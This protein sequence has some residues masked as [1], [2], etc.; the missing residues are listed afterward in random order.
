MREL[1]GDTN[2]NR[3]TQKKSLLLFSFDDLDGAYTYTGDELATHYDSR[4]C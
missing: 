4:R 2:I 3:I 1:P